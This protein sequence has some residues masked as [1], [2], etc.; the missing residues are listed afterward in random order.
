MAWIRFVFLAYFWLLPQ[1][2]PA[3]LVTAQTR[4]HA[5]GAREMRY[6]YRPSLVTPATLT[7]PVGWEQAMLPK[8]TI[9]YIERGLNFCESFPNVTILFSDIIS[10]TNMAATMTPLEVRLVA[11]RGDETPR[12]RKPVPARHFL[13]QLKRARCFNRKPVPETTALMSG[14]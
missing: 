13:A 7:V 14:A 5:P 12:C 4:H 11:E 6:Q 3:N 9:P 1:K 2:P 10:Y 8:K